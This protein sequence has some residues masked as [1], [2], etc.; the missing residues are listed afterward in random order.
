[1]D[2]PS[3]LKM[4]KLDATGFCRARTKPSALICFCE[5]RPGGTSEFQKLSMPDPATAQDQIILVED[6]GL[7]WGD[8]ALRHTQLDM[9]AAPLQDGD[10]RRGTRMVVTNLGQCLKTLRSLME[11]DPIAAIDDKLVLFQQQIL[12]HNH[13][14]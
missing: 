1:M 6:A 7:S 5:K 12:T 9:G 10:R 8:G 3:L 2:C 14:V 4:N 11:S 13:A